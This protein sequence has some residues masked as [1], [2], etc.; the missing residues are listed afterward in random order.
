MWV[1]EQ[2]SV[3]QTHVAEGSEFIG[4]QGGM[5]SSALVEFSFSDL[6]KS[7]FPSSTSIGLE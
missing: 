1:E 5:L 4:K 3:E 2:G 6:I 7:D